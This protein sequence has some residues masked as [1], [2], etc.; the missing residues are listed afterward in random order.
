MGMRWYHK[1]QWNKTEF[2]AERERKYYSLAPHPKT[3]YVE[4]EFE[5]MFLVEFVEGETKKRNGDDIAFCVVVLDFA[6]YNNTAEFQ[7]A[8][9]LAKV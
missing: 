8:D 6:D 4:Q 3:N 5:V 1:T 7:Y 2:Y 9:T